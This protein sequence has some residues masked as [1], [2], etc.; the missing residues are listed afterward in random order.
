MPR[1]GLRSS[2]WYKHRVLS[3]RTHC[4]AL[5][6]LRSPARGKPAHHRSVLQPANRCSASS[7]NLTT[8]KQAQWDLLCD[9]QKL[10][11]GEQKLFCSEL[12]HF[13]GERACPALGC[14]AAP[15]TNTASFQTERSV[16][17]WGRCEAAPGT[18]TAPF[19]TERI[20]WP[21]GRFA[22][23]RGASP[24]TTDRC[25]NLLTRAA[26]VA[27]ITTQAGLIC[28]EQPHHKSVLRPDGCLE[29]V[30]CFEHYAVSIK[31]TARLARI[32]GAHAEVR[33]LIVNAN[34]GLIAVT[35]YRRTGHGKR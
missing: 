24:L 1:A 27:L 17:P 33:H 19:Q 12:G 13:C 11:S 10:F 9:E 23:L 3:D 28:G 32:A 20:V 8:L 4:L 35:R 7:S 2:P 16:W 18:N 6:P 15:G 5:G 26:Q 34:T 22:A 14:E 29:R 25:C 30:A 21:W 31:T